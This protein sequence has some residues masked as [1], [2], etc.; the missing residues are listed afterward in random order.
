M[1]RIE[2]PINQI[3]KT[4]IKLRRNIIQTHDQIYQIAKQTVQTRGRIFQTAQFM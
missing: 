3:R 1:N 2:G 4:F